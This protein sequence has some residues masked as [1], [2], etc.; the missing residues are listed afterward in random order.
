MRI[1]GESEVA[2]GALSMK[3]MRSQE[4]VHFSRDLLL[5]RVNECLNKYR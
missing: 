5:E 4:Q 3:D 2:E 1:C